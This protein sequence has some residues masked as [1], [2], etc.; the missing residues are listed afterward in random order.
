MKN[1]RIS[2]LLLL[3]ALFAALLSGCGTEAVPE[4]TVIE[5]LT[6]IVEANNIR[7]LESYPDLK[8]VDLT[9]STCYDAIADYI[10]KNPGIQVIY[11]IALGGKTAAPDTRELILQEGEYDYDTLL[12]NLRYLPEL[13]HV[14]LPDSELSIEAFQAL[15]EAYPDISI[16]YTAEILGKTY[17]GDSE[18]LNFSDLKPEQVAAAAEKLHILKNVKEVELMA[19]DGTAQLSMEDVAVLQKAMPNAVFHY[20]FELF[21]REVSTTDERVEFKNMRL[22]DSY[23][24]ELRRALDIMHGC[25]YLLLDNCHFSNEVLAQIR[26][27][28]RDTTKVV[29][30]IYFAKAGSCL[31]DRTVIRYVYNLFNSNCS[32][33]VYCEDAEFIDFGHN[34]F[35]T[36]CTWVKHMTKLKAIILSGSMIAD[37]S[38]FANCESLEFL[39]VAYCGY[40]ED[41]SP[42]AQCKNLKMLNISFTK[43]ADIT[44]LEELQLTNLAG[45]KAKVTQEDRDAYA[46]SHPGCLM[47][48]DGA[49]HPY[50]VGWRYESDGHTPTEYYAKL[51]DAFGYPDATDT[52]W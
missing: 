3:L 12:E 28:Y 16:E 48:F 42:L 24:E 9:G 18:V 29:W 19:P 31:T 41:I 45:I 14:V 20:V 11:S 35:L 26:D 38:D 2:V 1:T 32:S 13:T 5:E 30:R 25:K 15:R 39:E 43:V 21:G 51:I 17:S 49:D 40:L 33:L 8:R 10:A 27:D 37:I 7:K 22:G 36:D 34:E 44:P 52:L 46:E 50:G 23:E 4:E 6:L 47:L